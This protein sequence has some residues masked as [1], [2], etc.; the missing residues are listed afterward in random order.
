MAKAAIRSR[1]AKLLLMRRLRALSATQPF[2]HFHNLENPAGFHRRAREILFDLVHELVI[3]TN[4]FSE[5]LVLPGQVRDAPVQGGIEP[6]AT[7]LVG[8]NPFIL[9]RASG[10]DR[11]CT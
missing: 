1:R 7:D 3:A 8:S 4:L 9:Y 5:L 2:L 6:V 11:Q 10:S